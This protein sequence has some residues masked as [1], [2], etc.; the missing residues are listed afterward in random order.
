LSQKNF[1]NMLP[2]DVMNGKKGIF[3]RY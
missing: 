1:R 3:D 2:K